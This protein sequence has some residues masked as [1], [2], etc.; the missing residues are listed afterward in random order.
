ML[1][2]TI[3][4][5]LFLYAYD[6]YAVSLLQQSPGDLLSSDL[7]NSSETIPKSFTLL[8]ATDVEIGSRLHVQRGG[9]YVALLEVTELFVVIQYTCILHSMCIFD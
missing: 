2:S 5:E 9:S 8:Q 3:S 6:N 4:I 1:P 7:H